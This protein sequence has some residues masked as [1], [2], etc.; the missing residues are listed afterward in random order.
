MKKLSTLLFIS[1]FVCL[2]ACGNANQAQSSNDNIAAPT[3]APKL[4]PAEEMGKNIDNVVDTLA[5]KINDVGEEGKTVVGQKIDSAKKDIKEL[6]KD[7]KE[8]AGA[9]FQK[10]KATATKVIDSTKSK[11][12]TTTVKVIDSTKAK[13]KATSNAIK[14]ETKKMLEK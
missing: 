7:A 10:G 11:V 5:T 2:S 8:Q 3:V 9:A 14:K 12:K 6:A 4:G 1:A 13:V